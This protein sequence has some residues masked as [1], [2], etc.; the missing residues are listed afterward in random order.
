[1]TDLAPDTEEEILVTPAKPSF[2][3]PATPP[4]TGYA[5]RAATKKVLDPNSPIGPE[6]VE[7][8]DP[9]QCKLSKKLGHSDGWLRT[10]VAK[11]RGSEALGKDI[12]GNKRV[13]ES[14]P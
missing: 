8:S 10:R 9:P 12:E 11:K 5:T 4:M 3:T 13:K 6:P 14:K 1:M 2:T 7:L